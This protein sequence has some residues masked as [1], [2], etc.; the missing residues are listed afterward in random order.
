MPLPPGS[1]PTHSGLSLHGFPLSCNSVALSPIWLPWTML[2]LSSPAG[3]TAL[4]QWGEQWVDRP[5]QAVSECTVGTPQ[6]KD[7]QAG[8]QR[9]TPD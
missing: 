6:S 2:V 7:A 5:S 3:S 4:G 8:F 1:P 9:G